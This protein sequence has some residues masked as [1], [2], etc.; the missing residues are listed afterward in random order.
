MTT[1]ARKQ[2]ASKEPFVVDE[3]TLD[4]QQ[5]RVQSVNLPLKSVKLD[6]RNPRYANTV[7]I[8]EASDE[9][10]MQ[11]RLENLLWEDDDVHALYRQVLANKGLIE[12]IIV[13]HDGAV[14][15]GNCRTVVYRKLRENFPKDPTWA[16]IPARVLPEDIGDKHVAILLGEMHVAG[17]NTW[18]PFEKAG[19]VYR[20]HKEFALNQEEIAQRLRMSK[21]KVN[22][23]IRAF[24]VMKNQYLV[25]YPGPGAI[26]RFSH[27]EELFKKPELRDWVIGDDSALEQFVDWVGEGKLGQG[28]HVRDLVEILNNKRALRAL[29]TSGYPAAKQILEEENPT[30]TSPL[31]KRMAEMT[32]AI[33]KVQLDEIQVLRRTKSSSARRVVRDLQEELARFAEFCGLTDD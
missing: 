18:S 33:R 15:E 5:I 4:G 9:R 25:K 31:F 3:I 17:K 24:D 10:S 8:E 11:E 26:R 7:A 28:I 32:D 21:S 13:R 27:F 23:L 1:T 16:H 12:R 29:S 22:Q 6:P 14:A 20:L 30:I 2:P 19:H